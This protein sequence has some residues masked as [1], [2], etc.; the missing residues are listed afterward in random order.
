MLHI[1]C[2]SPLSKMSSQ[3][4]LGLFPGLLRPPCE[5]PRLADFR[6]Q[7]VAN[8]AWAPAVLSL[9]L[10]MSCQALRTM[11]EMEPQGLANLAWAT[12]WPYIACN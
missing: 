8:S 2:T 11:P 4:A 5:P 3:R 7:D 6:A 12:R 9:R 10:A 1:L